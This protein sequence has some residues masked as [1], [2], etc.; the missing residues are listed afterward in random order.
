ME[1]VDGGYLAWR[2]GLFSATAWH[3]VRLGYRTALI[4]MDSSTSARKAAIPGYKERRA[5]KRADP[6][7]AA[8]KEQ[9]REFCGLLLDDPSLKTCFVDGMEADDLVA[10]HFLD[11]VA[12]LGQSEPCRIYA[13]DKDLLQVPGLWRFM[14]NLDNDRVF[15][16]LHLRTAPGYWP[17][18]RNESDVLLA[19]M[20]FGDRSD[21]IPRLLDRYD[22]ITAQLIW[23]HPNPFWR[24]AELWGSRVF[25]S[26]VQLLM[27]SPFLHVG[28]PLTLE[29][30]ILEVQ[31]TRY[32]NAF[33]F[34][35]ACNCDRERDW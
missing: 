5:Q 26:L 11:Y 29:E 27:P 22:R 14:H 3:S 10:I 12:K 7:V 13:V 32:W 25:D 18:Y 6:S 35:H 30:L 8:K 17:G 9:V 23:A 4:C 31:T 2:Y 15:Q 19:Q 21:S 28:W 16:R 34:P 33:N 20:L 24:C 1:I